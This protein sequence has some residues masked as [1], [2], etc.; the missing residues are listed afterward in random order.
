MKGRAA[1]SGEIREEEGKV[2]KI[3]A[4]IELIKAAL[5]EIRRNAEELPAEDFFEHLDELVENS[6][7]FIE[8][9]DDDETRG[10]LREVYRGIIRYALDC[11]IKAGAT[12]WN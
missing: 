10:R 8:S 9:F 3:V 6:R 12:R 11:K 4:P 1:L 7:R 5:G 2:I